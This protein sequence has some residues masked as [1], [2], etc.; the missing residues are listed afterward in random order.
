MPALNWTQPAIDD[1]WAIDAWLIENATGEIAL[2]T[3][4]SIRFRAS[5]LEK[6]PHGGRPIGDG[7]RVLRVIETPHLI[8]Y[9]LAAKNI[10]ILRV[11]HEREDWFVGP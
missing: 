10:E 3:L 5:F 6:F 4:A 1:L 2:A 7:V 11:R 8:F 9:R